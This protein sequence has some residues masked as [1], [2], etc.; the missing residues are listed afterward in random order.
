MNK[1]ELQY[2]IQQRQQRETRAT[3]NW[4]KENGLNADTFA[5]TRVSLLQAQKAAHQAKTE[6]RHYLTD[7]DIKRIEAFER[8]MRQAH[9]RDKL[10]KHAANPIF[11][12]C[13][14]AKRKA[15]QQKAH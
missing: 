10:P 3:N 12:I 1:T 4:L 13:T 5:S 2:L 15:H 11:Q 9:I 8:K 14:K 6:L 7:G